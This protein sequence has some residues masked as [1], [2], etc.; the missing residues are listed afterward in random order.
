MM[1]FQETKERKTARERETRQRMR[2][3]AIE[4]KFLVRD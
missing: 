1:A 4:I 3:N 2:E